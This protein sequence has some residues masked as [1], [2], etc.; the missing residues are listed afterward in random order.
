MKTLRKKFFTFLLAI[1][2]VSIFAG[3]I[4]ESASAAPVP[5]AHTGRHHRRHHHR[6]HHR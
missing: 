6:R 5:A 4:V 1:I 2:A 3:P